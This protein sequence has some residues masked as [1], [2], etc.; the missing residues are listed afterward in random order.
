[1]VLP[2]KSL[3]PITF[4]ENPHPVPVTILAQRAFPETS[5]VR[6]YPFDAPESIRIPWNDHVQM[7][8]S[9]VLGVDVPIPTFAFEPRII[10]LLAPAIALA[11]IAVALVSP[12]VETFAPYPRAELYVPEE[13]VESVKLPR[14]V[15]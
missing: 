3:A 8:S 4:P 1:M 2:M 10:V 14:A 15:L 5:E 7:T 11:P 6:T 9:F 13:F 12:P